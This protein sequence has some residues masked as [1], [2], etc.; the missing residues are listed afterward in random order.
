MRLDAMNQFLW[1]A[2]SRNPIIPAPGHMHCWIQE[3]YAIAQ[4][5][6]AP[7]IVKEPTVEPALLVKDPLDLKHSGFLCSDLH[8]RHLIVGI[9]KGQ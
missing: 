3:E 5:I 6:A 1:G 7:E 9:A 8:E 4:R 2:F